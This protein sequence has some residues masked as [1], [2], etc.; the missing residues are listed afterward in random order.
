MKNQNNIL[1]IEPSW[2]WEIIEEEVHVNRRFE[3]R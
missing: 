1:L 2:N 3:T